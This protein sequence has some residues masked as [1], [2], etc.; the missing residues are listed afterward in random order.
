MNTTY[1]LE[2]IAR[3]RMNETAAIA[4]TA[5]QRRQTQGPPRMALPQG[6]LP[7]PPPRGNPPPRLNHSEHR[8]ARSLSP[9]GSRPVQPQVDEPG[10]PGMGC[11]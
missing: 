6:H 9:G 4:R 8:P 1:A 10:Q 11:R 5:S 7:H 2:T 3:Q